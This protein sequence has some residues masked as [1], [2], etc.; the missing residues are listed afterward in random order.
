MA[1]AFPRFFPVGS[2]DSSEASLFLSL[3]ATVKRENVEVSIEEGAAKKTTEGRPGAPLQVTMDAPTKNADDAHHPIF[4]SERTKNAS[5]C[6]STRAAPLPRRPIP[7][8][9]EQA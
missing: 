8:Q 3:P 9:D 7:C 2:L 5:G 1:N 6:A 4:A